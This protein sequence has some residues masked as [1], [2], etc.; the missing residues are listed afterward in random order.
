MCP[1]ELVFQYLT[2]LR[3]K[4]AAPTKGS[5]LMSSIF[6]W[7]KVCECLAAEEAANSQKCQGLAS[8]MYAGKRPRERADPV[9]MWAVFLLELVAIFAEDPTCEQLPAIY[10]YSSMPG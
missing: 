10:V 3:F 5:A 6:F 1:E 4:P 8:L 9:P 2:F 7:A